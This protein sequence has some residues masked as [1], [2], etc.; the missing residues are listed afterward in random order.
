MQVGDILLKINGKECD[1]WRHKQAQDVIVSAGNYL[2][3]YLER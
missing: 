3:I 2:E 1:N